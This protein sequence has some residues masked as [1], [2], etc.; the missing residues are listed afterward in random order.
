MHSR[1]QNYNNKHA[2]AA[3]TNICPATAWTGTPSTDLHAYIRWL[4]SLELEAG[5]TIVPRTGSPK[6]A[7]AKAPHATLTVSKQRG[8]QP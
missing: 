6:V 7:E 4:T 3:C 2:Y 1:V 8:L 5:T